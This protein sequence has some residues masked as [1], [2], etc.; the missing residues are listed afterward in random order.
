M[1]LRDVAKGTRATK[2]VTFRLANSPPL[3]PLTAE[4][5]AAGVSVVPDPAM[6]SALVRVLNDDERHEIFEQ[7]ARDAAARGVPEWKAEHPICRLAQ[8][9]RTIL[10]ACEDADHPGQPFFDSI[11][12][13]RASY[14]I[15]GDN[16]ALLYEAQDNW[17]QE[18]SFGNKALSAEQ[19]ISVIVQEAERPES[20]E[21]PFARLRPGFA[22]SC[23]RF[24]AVQWCSSLMGN[25]LISSRS[26]T[27]TSKSSK[28]E[29]EPVPPTTDPAPA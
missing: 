8:M 22:A 11:E 25:W 21:S 27:A 20:A 23:L 1:K 15:G 9:E 2:L 14:E 6:V 29:N 10:I 4:Q 17:Q 3:P 12:Q 28:S 16:V 26:D 7:A 18:C 19:M 13:I 5:V 24:L